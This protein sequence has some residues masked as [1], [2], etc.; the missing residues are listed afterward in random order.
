MRM[1]VEEM[2]EASKYMNREAITRLGRVRHQHGITIAIM[3][4]PA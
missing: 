3:E 2:E 1:I 4:A